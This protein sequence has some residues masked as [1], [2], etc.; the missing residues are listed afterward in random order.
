VTGALRSGRVRFDTLEAY[1]AHLEATLAGDGLPTVPPTPERVQRAL[2]VLDRDPADVVAVLPPSRGVATV[3][4]VVVN[5]VMAGCRPEAMALVVAAI[6]ACAD[7]ALNLETL[8]VTSNPATTMVVVNGPARAAAGINSAGNCFAQ[9]GANLAVGRAVRLV[10]ANIGG[11]RPGLN[12][13]ACQ[14]FPG[15]LAFCF[16]E[17][18][19]ASPWDPWHVERGL[20]RGAGAVT[21][22]GSQGTS[23]IAVHGRGDAHDV[24]LA[25]TSGMINPGANNFCTGGGEPM[26]V[27]NPGHA[28]VLA[29]GGLGKD[30]LR[31]HLFDHARV[32]LDWYSAAAI[33]ARHL[34]E[35]SVD[36]R[37]LIADDPRDIVVL[38]AGAPGTHSTFIPSYG[39]TRAVTRQV[40]GV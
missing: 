20:A 2:D 25:I 24:L 30:E 26:I 8:Q 14:G 29:D 21:I 22:V 5:A 17:N 10:L 37:V 3:E 15:K 19:E 7:P 18:E 1:G 40:P 28:A 4:K 27:L 31:Q 32:P 16:G 6:E 11:A 13:M 33:E 12:D 35:R 23:N 9:G 34:S 38:V 36:G 39:D